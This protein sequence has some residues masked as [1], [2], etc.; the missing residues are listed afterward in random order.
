MLVEKLYMPMAD[1]CSIQISKYP[2]IQIS[3]YPPPTYPYTV[4]TCLV[5]AGNQIPKQSSTA[6]FRYERLGSNGTKGK[7]ERATSN[8]SMLDAGLYGSSRSKVMIHKGTME[9]HGSTGGARDSAGIT[10]RHLFCKFDPNAPRR[11][12][13]ESS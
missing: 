7:L 13:C 1:V 6:D 5:D 10:F 3:K 9:R 8:G 11:W 4:R 12:T 2:N